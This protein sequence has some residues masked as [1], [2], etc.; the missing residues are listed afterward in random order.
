MS[1]QIWLKLKVKYL[2]EDSRYLPLVG[3]ACFLIDNGCDWLAE[4]KFKRSAVDTLENYWGLRDNI[5]VILKNE[6]HRHFL[7]AK[8]HSES[9]VNSINVWV[10]NDL[11]GLDERGRSCTFKGGSQNHLQIP[12]TVDELILCQ[13]FAYV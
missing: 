5:V 3:I 9:E 11:H 2:Q 8:V 10:G 7:A 12:V 1:L 6:G 13:Y 4:N